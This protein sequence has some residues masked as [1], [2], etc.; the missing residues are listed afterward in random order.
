MIVRLLIF[1]QEGTFADALATRLE[2]EDDLEVVAALYMRVPSPQ[3]FT[4]S[5]A[6]VVLLDGDLADDAAFR[7]CEE[8]QQRGDMP[9][10]VFAL[11]RCG[12]H[13]TRDRRRCRRLGMQ[14]RIARSPDRSHPR[15][16]Q[17]RD[18]AAFA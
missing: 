14:G 8:L 11:R 9:R 13:R 6:D 10:V 1:V 4:G 17:R 16:G 12:T 2:A 5:R 3:L 7:L 15:C 18:L